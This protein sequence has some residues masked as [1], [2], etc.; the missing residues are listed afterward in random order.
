MNE[1]FDPK[2]IESAAARIAEYAREHKLTPSAVCDI[3][4]AGLCAARII[5]PDLAGEEIEMH[6][7]KLRGA[8]LL[9][10]PPRTP[11]WAA[12]SNTYNG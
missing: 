11:G 9:R 3:F 5:A 1:N 8:A 2:T 10:R 4:S 7:V 6:N 12:L